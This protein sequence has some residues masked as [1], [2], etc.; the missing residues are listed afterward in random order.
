M[1]NS[2]FYDTPCMLLCVPGILLI[3]VGLITSVARFSGI[4]S[5]DRVGMS[6]NTPH[7]A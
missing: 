6:T 5:P 7:K 4:F 1:K 3:V 2:V